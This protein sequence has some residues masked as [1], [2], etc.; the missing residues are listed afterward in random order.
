MKY[1]NSL[2]YLLEDS[3]GEIVDIEYKKN[4]KLQVH[5]KYRIS[6]SI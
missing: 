1:L 6:K 2:S 5:F 4:S 3:Y